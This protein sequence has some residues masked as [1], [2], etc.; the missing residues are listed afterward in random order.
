MKGYKA[1]DERLCCRPDISRK[2]KKY[3]VGCSYVLRGPVRL[4]RRGF[5]FC[6]NLADCFCHY[7]PVSGTRICEVEADEHFKI[8]DGKEGKLACRR[9]TILRELPK[10]EILDKLREEEETVSHKYLGKGW[11]P[12][13]RYIFSIRK[14]LE[15]AYREKG[16]AT[17]PSP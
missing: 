8:V 12:A 14:A 15:A 4:C 2:G 13:G 3:L 16:G 6:R 7:P 1:F 10:G 17:C 11:C 5:H 9:I